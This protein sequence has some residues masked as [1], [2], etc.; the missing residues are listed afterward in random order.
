MRNERITA[1]ENG[2]SMFMIVDEQTR[3]RGKKKERKKNSHT[4]SVLIILPEEQL[5]TLISFS[6]HE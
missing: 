2:F 3:S 1:E 6:M 4:L 5:F